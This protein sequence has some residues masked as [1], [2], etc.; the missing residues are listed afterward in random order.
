VPLRVH[1]AGNPTFTA[2]LRLV[3]QT[4]LEAFA[5]QDYPFALLVEQPQVRRDTDDTPLCQVMFML[6]KAYQLGSQDLTSFA[7]GEKG[8][9]LEVGGLCLEAMALEQQTATCDLTLTIVEVEGVLA[10]SLQY[11]T[12]LFDQLT[13]RRMLGHFQTLLEASVTDPQQ[14]IASLPMCTA[15]EQH[16]LLVP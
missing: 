5:H 6:Q 14:R 12:A 3:H 1:L 4:V 15:V 9:Q 10:A 8:R 7:L 11:N 16:Q 2:L 13:M